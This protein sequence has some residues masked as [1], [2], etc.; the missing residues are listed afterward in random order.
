[1]DDLALKLRG[2]LGILAILGLAF[3]LSSARRKVRPRIILFGIGLQIA[4][5]LIV[6]RTDLGRRFFDGANAVIIGL[7][8]FS[9][10]GAWFVF[11]A[12]SPRP[13]ETCPVGY[14]F[15][16]Q[17]LTTIIFFASLMA[18][19][20]HLGIMQFVVRGV[21]WVMLRT[22]RTSGAETLS[23]SANI[24]VGQTEAPLLVK[25]FIAGMTRSEIMAV[26]TGGFATVAGGV[27]AAYVGM[28]HDAF[29]D[30]AGHLMAA[31][32]MAAPAGLMIAK[33]MVP[34]VEASATAGALKIRVEKTSVNVIDAAASGAADGMKLVLNVAAMLIAFVAILALLDFILGW[35]G[36]LCGCPELSIKFILQYLFAPLAY[37][38]GVAQ[39][40]VLAVSRLLGEKLVATEFVAYGSLGGMAGELSER[41]FMMASYALCGFANFAS[42]AIQIG[43]IG[44]MA[45]ERRP[46][47]AQL[48]LKAM[49]AGFLTTCLTAAV[50]G[51]V[52]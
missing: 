25:P 46:H 6:L 17:T 16:F 1:M 38:M 33:I 51:I 36:G 19:L 23:A 26:M 4:F 27:M 14:L 35:A 44:A 3:L 7:L 8:D 42:I 39:G 21:A 24:F 20:Y 47:L 13:G 18:V 34:E 49:F 2:A 28:C 29:P 10:Q 50:A 11:G 37:A 45:P 31:S 30:I 15:F 41:S 22:M 5:A 52:I 32:V 43:G 9:K 12:L 40:D 48:G